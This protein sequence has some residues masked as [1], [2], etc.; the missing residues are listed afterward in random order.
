MLIADLETE[1][2]LK[3]AQRQVRKAFVKVKFSDFTRTTKECLS[4]NPTRETFQALLNEAYARGGKS[5]RLLGVGVR[6]EDKAEQDLQS[7]MSF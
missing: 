3:A 5:V 7:L 2:R 4:S 6:F 1:L